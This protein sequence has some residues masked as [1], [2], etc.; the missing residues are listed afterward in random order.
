[1]H[2]RRWQCCGCVNSTY[3][4][5]NTSYLRPSL[6]YLPKLCTFLLDLH[7][8]FAS[9]SQHKGDGPIARGQ[10]WLTTSMSKSRQPGNVYLRIDVEHG[11]KSKGNRLS[12]PC[13]CNCN[14]IST[15]QCHWPRLALDWCWRG[16]ALGTNRR[17]DVLRETS[18]VKGPYWSWNSVPLNL[19]NDQQNTPP[20][21]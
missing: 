4:D 5:F 1:M 18:L 8:K 14:N 2:L 15:A 6:H 19:E 3:N 16:E 20:G 10:Q 17:H 7:C 11:W 13:L 12:T 9:G 21:P